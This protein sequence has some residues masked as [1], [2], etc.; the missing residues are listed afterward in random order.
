MIFY[1]GKYLMPDLNSNRE[2][3]FIA[4]FIWQGKKRKL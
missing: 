3:L 1:V 4:L 2:K